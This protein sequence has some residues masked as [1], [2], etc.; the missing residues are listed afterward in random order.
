MRG[1]LAPVQRYQSAISNF[2]GN[3][4]RS[5]STAF[6]SPFS[7]YCSFLK[8]FSFSHP[9]TICAISDLT[10][11]THFNFLFN[12]I[13]FCLSLILFLFLSFSFLA[14]P[15]LFLSYHIKLYRISDN[16]FQFGQFTRSHPTLLW[17]LLEIFD[18]CQF[19]PDIR[20]PD[21][22]VPVGKILTCSVQHGWVIWWLII[23]CCAPTRRNHHFPCYYH[24]KVGR[25][26]RVTQKG[27]PQ[28]DMHPK[29]EEHI[30]S[31]RDPKYETI[32]GKPQKKYFFLVAISPYP[33]PF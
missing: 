27:W 32:L 6:L 5:A 22:H 17:W 3:W 33:P 26:Y 20:L 18:F 28:L 23:W 12:A 15:L 30:T 8:Y 21:I 14:I 29:T 11:L 7:L 2:T 31:A 16:V 9:H 25:I 19:I 10:R 4:I 24:R 13:Y 1:A